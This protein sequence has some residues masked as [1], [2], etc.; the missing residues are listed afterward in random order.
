[1]SIQKSI[2]GAYL[3]TGKKYPFVVQRTLSQSGH[4][5]DIC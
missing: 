3:F 2:V 4:S 1:M 5:K